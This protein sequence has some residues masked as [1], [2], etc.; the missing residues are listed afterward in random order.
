MQGCHVVPEF[1]CL[2][3]AFPDL[4]ESDRCF[5]VVATALVDELCMADATL[6]S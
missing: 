1:S 6:L 5:Y 4:G 3:G 2:T